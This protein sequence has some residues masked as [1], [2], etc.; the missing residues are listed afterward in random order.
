[1]SAG[2]MIAS[3]S[4]SLTRPGNVGLTSATRLHERTVMALV[5]G[6]SDPAASWHLILE[7]PDFLVVDK[8]AGLLTGMRPATQRRLCS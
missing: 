2:L 4:L 3:L 6:S 5:P 1:M 7:A 8:E